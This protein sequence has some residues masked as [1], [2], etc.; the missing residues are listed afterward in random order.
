MEERKPKAWTKENARDKITKYC[1]YQERCTREVFE[2][3]SQHRI[4]DPLRQMII[5]ELTDEGYIDEIRYTTAIVKGKS[6]LK[7]G[8]S[9]IRNFLSQK[10]IPKS[11]ID[12]V[13]KNEIDEEDT[14]AK[15]VT[16]ISR[17]MK[18]LG[19]NTDFKT[20]N[21]VNTLLI[22]KGYDMLAIKKGWEAWQMESQS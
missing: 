17:K 20:K 10:N 13:L 16:V 5:D 1:L 14:V 4:Y 15:I 11:I 8:A 2:K 7:W 9:K 6:R 12:E 21:K 3:L 19:S 22:S 18:S